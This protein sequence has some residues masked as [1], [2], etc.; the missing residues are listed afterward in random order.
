MFTTTRIKLT[1]WYL[2]IIM[3]IST[4]FSIGIYRLLTVEIERGLRMQRFRLEFPGRLPGS[5]SFMFR[6]V[7]PE[8]LFEIK[9]RIILRLVG[10]NAVIFFVTALSGYI[11][12]GRTLK[13]I[14]EMV[15]DQKRFIADAS[16]EIRT[17]LTSM[18]TEIEVALRDKKLKLHNARNL[19][20]SNLEEINKLQEFSN[21]LLTLSRYQNVSVKL[22]FD[23]LSLSS[24]LEGAVKKI[25]PLAKKKKITVQKEL[26]EAKI[27]GNFAS[28]TELMTI[29]LDNAIKYSKEQ[30]RVSLRSKVGKNHVH[31]QVEDF[32]V[33]IKED[34]VPYIFNRFYRADTSRSKS[35]RDGYGLGLSIAKSIVDLHNGRITVEST[36][37]KGSIFTVFL[38][39]KHTRSS[40][41]NL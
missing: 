39:M 18:K 29:L 1:G 36:L 4:V 6:A 10:I 34:D 33:G 19:L 21:Y 2:L 30:G 23:T 24:I 13:P 16:H 32:G 11:L 31:I 20:T 3:V 15:N 27:E 8:L 9:E 14:E 38:P 41:N 40:V 28:L 25:S 7:D 12:A 17:P 22:T 37:N 26:E 5:G 35:Y